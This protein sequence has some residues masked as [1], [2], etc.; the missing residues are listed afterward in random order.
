M[1]KEIK[2]TTTTAIQRDAWGVRVLV[3]IVPKEHLNA[4]PTKNGLDPRG[5]DTCEVIIKLPEQ[6]KPDVAKN[7]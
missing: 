5:G 4:L 2:F 7:R 6:D 3:I 1:A